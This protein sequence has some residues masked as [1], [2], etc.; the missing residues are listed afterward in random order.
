MPFSFT[1]K[2]PCISEQIKEGITAHFNP[3][4]GKKRLQHI[5][6]FTPAQARMPLSDSL[7]FPKDQLMP[8]CGK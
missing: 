3:Q 4:P 1:D 2:H 7:N 6:Q 8:V 5:E